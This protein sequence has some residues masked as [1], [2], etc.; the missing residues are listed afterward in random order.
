M[1]LSDI[2]IFYFLKALV[3]S[4]YHFSV[5]VT[6][7]SLIFSLGSTRMYFFNLHKSI[8]ESS[9]NQSRL[10]ASENLARTSKNLLINLGE[11]LE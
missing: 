11:L 8:V 4:L 10:V 7:F 2:K 6:A 9:K 5:L 1:Y 3:D